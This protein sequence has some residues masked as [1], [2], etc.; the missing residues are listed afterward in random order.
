VRPFCDQAHYWQVCFDTN[1][2]IR[3]TF[4]EAG[5]PNPASRTRWEGPGPADAGPG[6][7]A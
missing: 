5:F 4:A 1:R 6:S 2:L 7:N 3:E